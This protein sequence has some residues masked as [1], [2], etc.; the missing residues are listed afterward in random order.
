MNTPK[1]QIPRL[2]AWLLQFY[3]KETV[4]G[5][6]SVYLQNTYILISNNTIWHVKKW[7][8]GEQSLEKSKFRN[9]FNCD[10]VF[11][12]EVPIYYCEWQFPVLALCGITNDFFQ[13]I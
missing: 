12:D 10:F 2:H 11:S 13:F 7:N 8:I 9:A 4:Q 6:P 1:G 5:E 3:M